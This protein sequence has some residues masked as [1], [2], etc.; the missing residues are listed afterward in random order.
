MNIEHLKRL[1]NWVACRNMGG[2]MVEAS[3]FT[4][5]YLGFSKISQAELDDL[6]SLAND[7]LCPMYDGSFVV[8]SMGEIMPIKLK[9]A[10]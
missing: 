2:E 9:E 4:K 3:S 8:N 10:M 1:C 5:E 7:Y 6:C